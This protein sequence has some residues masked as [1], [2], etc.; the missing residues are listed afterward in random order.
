MV[1][2]QWANA[3]YWAC[4]EEPDKKRG[5]IASEQPFH[6]IGKDARL[7]V[8]FTFGGSLLSILWKMTKVKRS[9]EFVLDIH[10]S[11]DKEPMYSTPSVSHTVFVLILSRF[12]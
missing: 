7:P 9:T 12:A 8:H 1:H 11:E 5:V 6:R 4:H 10:S 3:P 2:C